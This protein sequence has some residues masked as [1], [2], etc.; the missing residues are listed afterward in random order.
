MSEIKVGDLVILSEYSAPCE[1]TVA[2]VIGVHKEGCQVRHL[3]RRFMRDYARNN[4]HLCPPEN[5]VLVSDFG[6]ASSLAQNENGE[7]FFRFEQARESVV[8]YKTD[9]A[10][11]RWQ[12]CGYACVVDPQC[13]PDLIKTGW[14]VPGDPR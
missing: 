3:A 7:L 8:T 12:P 9:N 5:L 4:I 1:Q 6:I 13:F 10:I 14:L 11:R 2:L